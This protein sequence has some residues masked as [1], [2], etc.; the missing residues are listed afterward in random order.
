MT[1][2]KCED[3]KKYFPIQ[4]G[5]FK[6]K[7][8]IVKAVDGVTLEIKKGETFG[9]VGESGCGKTTLGKLILG[10]LKPDSG[11]ITSATKDLQAIFQDPYNSLD[12]KM[13]IYDIL[14]EGLVLK[15]EAGD[16]RKRVEDLLDL[17]RLPEDSLKK[18][19]HQFSG[20]ER[21]RIAIG[22]AVLTHP[23]FIVC[24]EPVSSL[25]VTIQLQIL[26]LLKT[27]QKKMS[28]TYLFISH[29]L[30]VVKFMSDRIAVMKDGRIIEEGAT[31]VV[32]AKPVHPYTKQLLSSVLAYG[33]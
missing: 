33:Y 19:P 18:Y 20:G 29:D 13:K 17:V 2:V 14:S 9:I 28:I 31:Q 23:E 24:D 11:S 30:R 10:I 16:M 3:L 22:R 12:P 6:G 27:I 26:K 4:R 5:A 7:A 25:D 32:Y 1:M 8:G 21:Q 15:R